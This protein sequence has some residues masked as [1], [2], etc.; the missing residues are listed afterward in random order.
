LTILYAFVGAGIVACALFMILSRNLVR[1][2]LGLSLLATGA[3]LLLSLVG[4]VRS[5][6]PP[7]IEEGQQTLNATAADPLAQAL[8]L[9]AIVIGFALTVVLAVLVLRAWR[10]E[11][12]VDSRQV[13]SAEA[14]GPPQ[15]RDPTN[16]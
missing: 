12:T 9:T 5:E 8:V 14:L 16:A 1:V 6:R 11:R 2:L 10:A 7:I 15:E 3:N 13:D 4:N